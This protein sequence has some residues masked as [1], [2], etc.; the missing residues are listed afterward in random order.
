MYECVCPVKLKTDYLD[1]G[2]NIKIFKLG[3]SRDN[4]LFVK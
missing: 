4:M 3:K 2:A 1:C